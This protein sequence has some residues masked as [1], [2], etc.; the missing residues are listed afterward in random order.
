MRVNG[1]AQLSREPELCR[2]FEMQ[3][4]VP[5]CVIVVTVESA[6]PQCQKALVRS[7]LWDP[8]QQIKR[9][10]LPSVGQMIQAIK[11]DFDGKTYDANYP[12]R[13]KQTIY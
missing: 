8:A 13:L 3:G 9:S 6:Y 2:S 1:R 4:K 7:K 5:A 10:E 11:A 12:E